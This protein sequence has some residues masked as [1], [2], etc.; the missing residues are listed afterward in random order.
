M[1][2][3]LPLLEDLTIHYYGPPKALSKLSQMPHLR[4]LSFLKSS[5]SQPVFI[6]MLPQSLTELDV[7]VWQ[8]IPTI[9]PTLTRLGAWGCEFDDFIPRTTAAF[10]HI[11]HLSLRCHG[12]Q[13]SLGLG[14]FDL[15]HA[16]DEHLREHNQALWQSQCRDAW[17]SL[18]SIWTQH[19][20]LLYCLGL[21]RH[22]PRISVPFDQHTG[23]GLLVPV[24]EDTAPSFLELRIGLD[25]YPGGAFD[26]CSLFGPSIASLPRLGLLLHGHDLGTTAVARTANIFVGTL[27]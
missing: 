20:C 9:F 22:V 12:V 25:V 13:H 27:C 6:G 7:D 15:E 26:W 10:P 24:L 23:E 18:S 5:Y 2:S 17:S 14:D 8:S 3:A 11:T 1:V 19:L 16:E 4:K 21:S